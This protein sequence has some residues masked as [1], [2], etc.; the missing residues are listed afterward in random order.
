[1]ARQREEDVVEGG[2]AQCEV[3]QRNARRVEVAHY[4]REQAG[5]VDDGYDDAAALG[6]EAGGAGGIGRER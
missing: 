1:V 4:A 3:I 2:A 6:V 5:A